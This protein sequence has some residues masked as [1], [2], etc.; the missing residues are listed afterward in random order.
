ML[1]YYNLC[2]THPR[3]V[4]LQNVPA[5][6]IPRYV[7]LFQRRLLPVDRLL[8]REFRLDDINTRFDELREAKLLRGLATE[9]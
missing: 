9:F 3:G 7:R 1:C 2:S 6:N 5:R 8:T 4:R